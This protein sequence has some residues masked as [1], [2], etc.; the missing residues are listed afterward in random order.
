[1][2]VVNYVLKVFDFIENNLLMI[3]LWVI[4]FLR[5]L[6]CIAKIFKTNQDLKASTHFLF[7]SSF[8][9]DKAITIAIFWTKPGPALFTWNSCTVLGNYCHETAIKTES[10]YL[11]AAKKQALSTWLG[12]MV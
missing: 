1:M 8:H 10:E 6:T 4:S 9:D 5:G 7:S 2:K 12:A 11:T 3:L